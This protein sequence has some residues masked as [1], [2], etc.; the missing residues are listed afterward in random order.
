MR[1]QTDCTRACN[2]P[3]AAKPARMFP[4]PRPRGGKR[5]S[6]CDWKLSKVADDAGGG[7]RIAI[8]DGLYPFRYSLRPE[9]T[10]ADIEMKGWLGL[11]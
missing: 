3:A 10:E 11:D 8:Q 9:R 2:Q 1:T 5:A 7:F 6:E 4:Q